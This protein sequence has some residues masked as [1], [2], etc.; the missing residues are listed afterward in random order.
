[1]R[2]KSAAVCV[3]LGATTNVL[4]AWALSLMLYPRNG[5]IE[6]VRAEFNGAEDVY[7]ESITSGCGVTR[8][9][10]ASEKP[11][12][13]GTADGTGHWDPPDEARTIRVWRSPV[14]RVDGSISWLE[15]GTG[16]PLICLFKWQEGDREL[17]GAIPLPDP[18]NQFRVYTTGVSSYGL[19]YL[20]LWPQLIA[21]T[22]FWSALWGAALFLPGAVRRRVRRRRGQCTACGYDL[23][24]S[25]GVCPE[26]GAGTPSEP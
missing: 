22:L 18:S 25:S 16:F 11:F 19:P 26:C 2:L 5:W 9:I 23:S 8:D 6:F 3:A 13:W 7:V 10:V 20:P 1:L 17:H 14:S 24:A 21:N 12:G 4:V 15:M